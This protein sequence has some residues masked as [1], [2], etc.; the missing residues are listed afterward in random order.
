[1]LDLRARG[2]SDV[3]SEE[4]RGVLAASFKSEKRKFNV[5]DAWSRVSPNSL[6]LSLYLFLRAGV[7]VCRCRL[8]SFDLAPLS[9]NLSFIAFLSSDLIELV[10]LCYRDGHGLAEKLFLLIFIF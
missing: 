5:G 8:P 3:A 1:M 9:R 7:L 4:R 6:S 2:Q 10:F